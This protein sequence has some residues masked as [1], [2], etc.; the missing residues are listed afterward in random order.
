[1]KVLNAYLQPVMWLNRSKTSDDLPSRSL[2]GM[3]VRETDAILRYWWFI[4]LF[5][6]SGIT[7]AFSTSISINLFFDKPF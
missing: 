2:I 3:Y 5:S 7:K 1:M 6:Y 4:I